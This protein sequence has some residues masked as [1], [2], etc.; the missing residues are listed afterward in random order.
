MILEVIQSN[1]RLAALTQVKF[2]NF[3]PTSSKRVQSG[4][5]QGHGGAGL[6]VVW[7]T[8]LGKLGRTDLIRLNA[9]SGEKLTFPVEIHRSGTM[10]LSANPNMVSPAITRV[11]LRAPVGVI[12]LKGAASIAGAVRNGGG[13]RNG[14]D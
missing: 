6:P 14:A 2:S 7:A 8:R 9:A 11:R 10:N 13:L 3:R 4:R 5:E 12:P 1:D